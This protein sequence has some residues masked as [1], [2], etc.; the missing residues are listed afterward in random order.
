[1]RKPVLVT[2]DTTERPEAMEH[3]LA[4]PVGIQL[5]HERHPPKG[6]GAYRYPN[7]ADANEA[8]AVQ[9]TA[10]S[11]S[12]NASTAVNAARLVSR[13]VPACCTPADINRNPRPTSS[14][15]PTVGGAQFI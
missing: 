7:T 4:K 9:I 6:S 11:P 8:K 15:C 10:H 12:D 3:G 5:K 13:S 2:R 14:C 1:M